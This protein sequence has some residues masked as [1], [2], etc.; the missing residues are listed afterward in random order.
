M[1]AVINLDKPKGITSHDA[2]AAVRKAL[3]I[4]KAGHA[5]TLDP[6]ATGVLL[7]GLGEATKVT[8]FLSDMPKEYLAEIKLGEATDTL[9][10]EGAI[11]G[12]S[13]AP[14]PALAEIETALERFK[15]EIVQV[16]P[17]YSALKKDGRPLYE[18]ARKGVEVERAERKVFVHSISVEGYEPP[19]LTLLIGCSK[20][21]YIRTLAD[22]L[23]RQLGTLAHLTGLRRTKIGHFRAEDS[24]KLHAVKESGNA[25]VS[26]DSALFSLDELILQPDEYRLLYNGNP[27]TLVR[28]VGIEVGNFIRLKSPEG[29]LFAIGIASGPPGGPG[30]LVIKVER[31]LNL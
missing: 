11:T 21:T 25:F 28:P 5:G 3:G 13:D 14:M 9:D 10:A 18:L 26:I 1:N 7:I 8:R 12:R 27:V 17:M 2:V 16:P 29:R 31:R 20:G 4:K 22:D 19:F 6:M 30:R 23:G 24:V 15:G